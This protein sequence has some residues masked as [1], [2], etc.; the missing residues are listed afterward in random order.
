[1]AM[2]IPQKVKVLLVLGS[3]PFARDPRNVIVHKR[4]LD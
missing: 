1:M 2:V 3:K 4:G